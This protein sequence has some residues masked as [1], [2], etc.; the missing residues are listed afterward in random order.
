M[1]TE[2]LVFKD[3]N[4]CVDLSNIVYADI[5]AI[6]ERCDDTSTG[7][8]QKH[9]PCCIGA[10]WVSKGE[11]LANG[12][13]YH[14]FKGKE[15]INNFVDYIEELATYIH[16][17]NK[18]QTRVPALKKYDEIVKHDAATH[19]H[20]CKNI[21]DSTDNLRKK[22]FDHDHLTGEYRGAACQGCNNKLR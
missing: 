19:C 22:V 3:F 10:Y 18:S 21:F 17:R 9:E 12:G 16:E 4:K 13:E 8:L 1:P 2:P 5:E 11:A 6:L 14:D 15:C 7:K 20:W